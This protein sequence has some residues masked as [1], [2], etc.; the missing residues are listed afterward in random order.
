MKQ[1]RA[2][3]AFLTSPQGKQVI[4]QLVT[5]GLVIFTALKSAGI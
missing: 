2:L 1:L 5:A 3:V 4:H